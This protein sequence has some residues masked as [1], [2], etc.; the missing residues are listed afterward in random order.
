MLAGMGEFI[1]VLKNR[2]SL[3]EQKKR[4]GELCS[5]LGIELDTARPNN[6]EHSGA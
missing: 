5:P 6:Q 1:L 3:H 2:V 4:S